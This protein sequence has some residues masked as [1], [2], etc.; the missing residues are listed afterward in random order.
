MLQCRG[1]QCGASIAP[2][3]AAEALFLKRS[4]LP[5]KGSLPLLVLG[6]AILT[7]LN[8]EFA[9]PHGLC[10]SAAQTLVDDTQAEFA[11]EEHDKGEFWIIRG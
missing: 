8:N 5:R 2:S 11:Q 7:C 3:P 10:P 4:E 6:Q 1:S 9:W